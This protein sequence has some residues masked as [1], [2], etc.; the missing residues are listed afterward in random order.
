MRGPSERRCRL[1]RLERCLE[2]HQKVAPRLEAVPDSLDVRRRHPSV[3]AGGDDDHVL[4]AFLDE[5]ERDAGRFA[6]GREDPARVDA[7]RAQ[8]PLQRLAEDVAPDA[9][10][11]PAAPAQLPHGAGLVRPLA[12]GNRLEAPPGTVWPGSG[13]FSTW[14][15]KS[16]FRLPTTTM[17][18]MLSLR[19]RGTRTLAWA[20]SKS[21]RRHRSRRGQAAHDDE[22]EAEEVREE[23]D[24]EQRLGPARRRPELLPHEHSHKAAT[25]VAPWP[26]P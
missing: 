14:T 15:T 13:S 5:D 20:S 8:A 18:F 24:N 10:H 26:R 6:V 22:R 4:A 11:H 12:S 21:L 7:R 16:M 9:S 19:E 17:G 25:M 23:H 1:D 2:L 3:R